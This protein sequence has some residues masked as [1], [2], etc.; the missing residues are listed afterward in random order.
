MKLWPTVPM[1]A[2]LFGATTLLAPRLPADEWNQLTKVTFSGPVEIPGQVLPAGTYTFKLLDSQSDRNIVQVFNNDQTKLYATILAIPDERLQP[3]GK[4][5]ITFEE[6]AAGAPQAVEAWFYPGTEYGHE[7]VYPKVRAMQLAKLNNRPVASMP[8]NM[9]ATTKM[10]TKSANEP[11]VMALKK[12]P[13][14]AENPAGGEESL[15]QA[16]PPAAKSPATAT[17]TQLPATGS[18]LPLFALTG[19][20]LVSGGLSLRLLARRVN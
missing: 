17:A 5:V 9:E 14:K 1:L 3:T 4:T 20:V 8:D 13:V 2:C 18:L 12:A 11:Q 6:R 19:L 7:F 16:F 15:A 10:P